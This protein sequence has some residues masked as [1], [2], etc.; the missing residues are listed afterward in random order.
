[1]KNQSSKAQARYLESA[2]S[3]NICVSLGSNNFRSYVSIH[4]E[5]HGACESSG[6]DSGCCHA[7]AVPV[8]NGESAVH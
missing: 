6:R 4:V 3:I 2:V 1:M 5:A 7:L 8:Q